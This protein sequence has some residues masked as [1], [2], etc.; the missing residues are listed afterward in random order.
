MVDI[1]G[2][3][4][5]K[6]FTG[7]EPVKAIY[8]EGVR[9]WPV[10]DYFG[11]LTFTALEDITVSVNHN[12]TNQTTTKPN[13]QYSLDGRNW[14]EFNND[15]TVNKGNIVYLKGVNDS[16]SKTVDNFSTFGVTGDSVVSGNIM[17]LLYG[18]DFEGKTD[19]SN[20]NYCFYKLF[21]NNS[22]ITSSSGLLLPA[23]TLADSQSVYSY[24]FWNCDSMTDAPELPATTLSRYAYHH[25]FDG[26]IEIT[27]APELP[28]VELVYDYVYSYMFANCSS[29]V[30]APYL[31]A[32]S[33]TN[34][35]YQYMF[36]NCSNLN[37]VKAELLNTPS[38]TYTNNWLS[39]VA[40]VGTFVANPD[41]TWTGSITRGG[42]TIPVN[43]GIEKDDP[44]PVEFNGTTFYFIEPNKLSMSHYGTNQTTT[45]PEI[46]YSLN[47][48]VWEVLP[49]DGV[50][51]DANTTV[52]VKGNNQTGISHSTSNYSTFTTMGGSRRFTMDGNVM[53][54]LY[55]DD[56][57]DKTD[58]SDKDYCFYRLFYNNLDILT[59]PRNFP[60]TTLGKYVY[61]EMFYGCDSLRTGPILPN[62]TTFGTGCLQAM[63][64]RCSDLTRVG[65]MTTNNPF[66][67]L[68]YNAGNWLY[69][70]STQN[71]TFVTPTGNTW[72]TKITRD[73]STVPSTWTIV[74]E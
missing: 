12:G 2:Q 16:F 18:S 15:V 41:A 47:G 64:Y 28:T 37:Y 49:D 4:I 45:K 31:P 30:K 55:G 8:S 71:G 1:I 22:D 43:W 51:I 57:E 70:V 19:L 60:A 40:N 9:V 52:Y 17:S 26:C 34:R 25:M 68:V 46:R 35:C 39:G 14:E 6:A 33:L 21:M 65:L 11:G 58:L 10:I 62:I 66:T 59:T 13:I 67:S 42:S 61:N 72:A 24:M 5:Q 7:G 23:T 20:K 29:L 48:R 73:P 38:T 69:G 54:L 44:V 32:V 74:Y 50:Y 63:F 3:M 27:E 36:Q 53:S 56:F